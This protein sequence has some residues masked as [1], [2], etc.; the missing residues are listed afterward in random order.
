MA[1]DIE[2]HSPQARLLG[3]ELRE[4]RKEA[5]LT[6]RD[7]ASRLQVGHAAVSRYETGVRSPAVDMLARILTALGA[8]SERYDELMEL[9]RRSSEP[10]VIG[11]SRSGLHK[12]LLN[13]AEFER[14][15]ERI[16]H[17]AP[18][19]IPGPLQTRSYAEQIMSSLTGEERDIRLELRMA[20]SGAVLASQKLEA[21]ICERVLHDD[22][23]GPSVLAEQLRHLVATA[24]AGQA[25]VRILPS[26]LQ[27]WTLAHNGS[28]VL[29]EFA[30][31]SPIVHLE[32]Y[33]GPAFIYD[34]KDVEAYRKALVTF[35]DAAMSQDES[36]ELMAAI[37]EQFERSSQV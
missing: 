30:K 23:G 21:V 10:N 15:A 27:R 18:M 34:Q 6:V 22:I 36:T 25:H 33:R 26:R 2:H 7:L 5:G 31:A 24:Q 20:R 28:F 4:L 11:D 17:V 12:H 1:G 9:A 37:A 14:T 3:A 29:F 19:V 32:H 35:T 13:L 16:V 8:P